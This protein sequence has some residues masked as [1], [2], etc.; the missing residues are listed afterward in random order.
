M[1]RLG[2]ANGEVDVSISLSARSDRVV[3]IAVEVVSLDRKFDDDEPTLVARV[4]NRILG[5]ILP[6]P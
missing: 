6:I 1:F 5:R 2:P 3:P 4:A